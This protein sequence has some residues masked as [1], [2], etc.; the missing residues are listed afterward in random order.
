MLSDALKKIFGEAGDNLASQIDVLF[1]AS[2]SVDEGYHGGDGK[3]HSG[4]KGAN[5]WSRDGNRFR[6]VVNKEGRHWKVPVRGRLRSQM[7]KMERRKAEQRDARRKKL[8]KDTS[9]PEGYNAGSDEL[10]AMMDPVEREGL[11]RSPL[12][13]ISEASDVKVD[14]QS[15]EFA[16]GQQPDKGWIDK[17]FATLMGF[18]FNVNGKTL[19]QLLGK[20]RRVLQATLE[21]I[22]SDDAI[23]ALQ[24]RT[25]I[26]VMKDVLREAGK[27][28]QA[29][30]VDVASNIGWDGAKVKG[31]DLSDDTSYWEAKINPKK[32][33]IH[34][35]VEVDVM[36]NWIGKMGEDVVEEVLTV[37]SKQNK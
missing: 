36:G 33:S 26:A 7:S 27:G 29:E 23:R 12:D 15:I 10:D 8:G 16:S 31:I 17:E 18:E 11:F 9:L 3:F 35:R 6:V 21:K 34:F 30:L 24:S 14:R 4:H 13:G 32:E 1:E 5:L 19:A 25:G 37:L 2:D 20:Q 22:K 28:I